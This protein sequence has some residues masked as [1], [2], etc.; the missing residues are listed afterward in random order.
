MTNTSST[1]RAF[2]THELFAG[3]GEMGELM[4]ARDW[5]RTPLG[6]P[7]QWPPSLRTAVRIILLSRYPMFIWWGKHL[8]NLYNDRY[9]PMLGKKHPASLGE[10]GS[11][12]WGDI[13]E[14]IRPRVE[15]VLERGEATFDDALLLMMNRY[16][17]LEETY[18]TFSYSP[19]PDDEGKI[20]G[21]FCAVT[22]ETERVISERRM[23]LLRKLASATAGAR[24]I[25]S[26]CDGTSKC[27]HEA[28]NDFPFLL[29]YMQE[30][31]SKALHL[32]CSVGIDYSHPAAP[33]TIELGSNEPW[34][35]GE[36]L[37]RGSPV[38]VE[39][40]ESRFIDLPTG[41]WSTPPN[42]A[43]LVPLSQ[44]GEPEHAGVL[45]AGI[46]P[47]RR[48][49]EEFAGFV[50]L[51]AGQITA[52]LANATAYDAERK[53]AEA[54]AELDRAKTTFFSNVSHEFR[55]PLTLM[56]GPTEDALASRARALRGPELELVHRNELRLLKL[57]NTLLDFS[58][59]EAG[60]IKAKYQRTDLAAFTGELASVF[61]SAMRR[62]RLAFSVDAPSLPEPVYVDRE[63]WEKIVLNLLSNALK[64][65]FDGGIAV[66]VRDA[67]DHA[68]I[69]VRDTGT[70]IPEEEIPHLFERF[71]RIENARTRTHEGSGIGLALVHE[72]VRMHGGKIEIASKFHQGTTFTVSIP[73][74][75]SHLPTDAM[76][77]EAADQVTGVA[78]SAFIQEA[79]SWMP[80]PGENPT[81]N[82]VTGLAGF[83]AAEFEELPPS[84]GESDHGRVLL[85]DDNRDMREYVE[86]LL[87]G[88]FAVT[89]APNGKIALQ[90]ALKNPPDIVLSDVMMPDMD[91]YQLLAELR[92][93]PATATV[94]VILL[95][96]RA[97][98]D[99]R[100]QGMDAGADDYLTKP[101]SARELLARVQ[102]HMKIARF[103]K[104]AIQH[105]MR[106]EG[107]LQQARRLAAEAVENI[108]DGFFALD[109][110]WRFTYLN[111]KAKQLISTAGAN[112]DAQGRT[113]WEVLPA[114][115]GSDIAE[116][117]RRCME[118]RI[119]VEF[120]SVFRDRWY[121]IRAY[122]APTG[123]VI[124]GVDVT[125]RKEAES[126]LRMKQEHLLLTQKTA[127]IGT[128]EHDI[129][130]DF[131]TISS[132]FAEIV[133]LPAY[134]SRM[135]Y[136][137]FLS[138]LFL[139]SDRKKTEEALQLA[140]RRKKEFS[141]ELRLKRPDG[142]VRLV[143]NRGK[144]FYNQGKPVVLGVLVDVT[145]ST[146][147]LE[148]TTNP[149]AK[150]SKK[151]FKKVKKI[152]SARR[153]A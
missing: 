34:P 152:K 72:L 106:L 74:G 2:N 92:K 17:Y 141:I 103:R 93:E 31:N 108:S 62:A 97:G 84:P 66:E 110:E 122:P 68:E 111:P 73:Y 40:L 77:E 52:G 130:D 114:L 30:P 126:E 94:P 8:V 20:G 112:G 54:L 89:A 47:H 76:N 27:L 60:R 153:T 50:G 88:R 3:G 82:A 127:K 12:T 87:R 23:G 132:E 117:Y 124:Y 85:V 28:N 49:D 80:T 48:M 81:G 67:G 9:V 128:W 101:F 121:A 144:V 24:T 75:T 32:V 148:V 57:V 70:G 44:Q 123:M 107:E 104:Q 21:L 91:G 149:I 102:A 116:Q 95:S 39:D 38:L 143:S 25:E 145:A 138:S 64:S 11:V 125:A 41:A 5:S 45:I 33:A 4:Q 22:E 19:L 43:L 79:L 18:F 14:S 69:S 139:S 51:I 37:S 99:S 65:T 1:Q 6:P 29:L 53:R 10:S 140:L 118:M 100:L 119:P 142:A 90:K 13:W 137:D 113:L 146:A 96:A 120:E 35:A 59:L 16:G 46:N 115:G 135:K 36:V 151:K 63:M 105:E 55:T 83:D 134:V 58:R 26:V 7:E 133:G 71:H 61:R 131:L 86:R 78:R 42:S 98:E 129:E 147:H 136:S 15:A 150:P 109:F 56:L